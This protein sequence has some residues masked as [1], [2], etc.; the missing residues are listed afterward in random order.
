[1]KVIVV[2]A[3][4][5]GVAL[6]KLLEHQDSSEVVIIESDEVRAR[7][8]SEETD[9]LVLHGD[10]THP[11]ML[12][13]AGLAEADALVAVTGSDA[14]NT[15]IAMLG[16][17]A[18]VD[19]IVVKLEGVGLRPACQELGVSDILSPNLASASRILSVLYGFKRMDLS[20]VTQGG[21]RLVELAAGKAAG[22]KLNE[23]D[24][25]DQARVIM[26][27]RG[28]TGLVPRGRLKIEPEDTLV[29]LAENDDV[30][31]RARAVLSP[32]D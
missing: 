4:S 6:A 30:L 3:G 11:E 24:L 8:V 26:V 9:A 27:L 10:G 23:I 18:G 7:A 22:L 1:M 5:I 17:R 21:L 31:A 14:I 12:Q 16:H 15:V 32:S 13:K 19:K 20:L 29:L 2:G 25:P 28:D